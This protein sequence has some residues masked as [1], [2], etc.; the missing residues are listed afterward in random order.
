M[1]NPNLILFPDTNSLLHYP[2]I[3]EVGWRAIC[4]ADEVKLVLCMQVINELDE[5][6]DDSRLGDRAR[7]AIKE[8]KTLIANGGLV[9]EGVTIEVFNQTLR[10]DEFTASLSPDSKDDNTVHL[11]KKYLEKTRP[12]MLLST[13]KIWA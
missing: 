7:R 2:P 1:A 11:V 4:I 5:K 3:K 13:R 9:R 8:I 10:A 6:K 12:Q